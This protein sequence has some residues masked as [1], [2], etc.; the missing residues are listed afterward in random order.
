MW[1][2]NNGKLVNQSRG[3]QREYYR[4]FLSACISVQNLIDGKFVGAV[5]VAKRKYRVKNHIRE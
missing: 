3:T 2:L 1:E 4:G 5:E